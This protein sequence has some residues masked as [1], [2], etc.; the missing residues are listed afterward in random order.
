[1]TRTV[2]IQEFGG[3]EQIA[4]V[5]TSDP[6]P[7]AGEVRVRVAAAGL[8]PIDLRIAEGG[9]PAARFGVTPPF[10]NGNDYAGVIDEVGEGV[11]AWAIG[12]RVYGGARCAAQTDHLI[13]TDLDTLNRTPPAL[14]DVTASVLDI[15][16][17]TALAGIRALNLDSS[18][19][20]LISA[21]AGGVGVLACQLARQTGATVLGTASARNHEFLRSLGVIPIAHG[22][23]IADRIAAA[24]PDG[25]TAVFDGYGAE[26]IELGLRLGV[27]PQRINSVADRSAAENLG[28]LSI[29]R[30]TTPTSAVREI[31]SAIADGSIIVNLEEV[32]PIEQARAAYERLASGHV[33]GKLTLTFEPDEREA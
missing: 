16:G 4:L 11:T 33:R 31:A 5:N 3:P 10:V 22:P 25:I 21:A 1:M 23:G 18:D 14:D 17:R 12:D 15:A 6:H 28:V 2:V 29:G 32:F 27:S 24:M 26:T 9:A 30:G 20:V 7:G 19:N 13:V 8:N